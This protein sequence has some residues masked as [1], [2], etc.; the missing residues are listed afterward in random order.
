VTKFPVRSTYGRFT[1]YA[2]NR[3][4]AAIDLSDNTNQWGAPP[5]ALEAITNVDIAR[6]PSTYAADLKQAVGDAWQSGNLSIVV[7]CGSD[8]VL[9]SAFRALA[10]PGER[11]A[12][13]T[14]TFPMV[15][16]FA[17]MNELEPVPVPMTHGFV[18]DIDAL[19]ATEAAISYVCSPNNPTGTS[20]TEA[21][22]RRLLDATA[23]AVVLDEAYVQFSDNAQGFVQL[24]SEYERLVVLRTFSKAYGLAGLRVGV[25]IGQP[26]VIGE[27]AKAIG[28]YKVSGVGAAAAIAA[29]Q[30][31][32][33]SW[34]AD[35]VNDVIVNRRQFVEALAERNI[36]VVP[37]EA[38]FVF[39][40]CPDAA[41]VAA[42][43]GDRGIAVR[44]FTN[45]PLFGDALRI[46][47]GPRESMR[48]VLDVWDE[49]R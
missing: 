16:S 36:D 6:Y 37:S 39:V 45:V 22:L 7:G 10:Q 28:P 17:L 4:A 30:P 11:V 27:V 15:P 20:I 46:T 8:D 23:G 3:I 42:G 43:F 5:A 29:L 34:V 12:F 24:C 40:R 26:A 14:P 35:R 38:N 2:P 48:K 25:G 19:V 9:D 32:S 49:L 44:W 41:D 13:S 1:T 18:T 33:A 47:I 21:E 31:E